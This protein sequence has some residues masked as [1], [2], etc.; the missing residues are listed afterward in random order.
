MVVLEAD[1]LTDK[2]PGAIVTSGT[3]DG[4]HIGHQKILKDIS[5]QAQTA[6]GHSVVLTFWPHPRFIINPADTTLK[7]LSTFEEKASLVEQANIDFLIKLRFTPA[8]SRMTPDEYVQQILID[9]LG[10]RKLVIG[11]DHRFG[12]G[13]EGNFSYLQANTDRFGFEVEEISR[14]DIDN[15]GVSSTKIRQ[16]LMDGHVY[17]AS[18]YLG[19]PYELS[20]TVVSGDKLGSTIGYPT[21]NLEINEPYKLV[22][23]EG[24]YAVKI[25]IG[26]KTFDGMMNIGTRPTV[27]GSVLKKEVH[28][29]DFSQEIYGQK[30]TIHFIKR[31]RDEKKFSGIDALKLQL[32]QDKRAAQRVLLK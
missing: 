19:R 17:V 9:K 31:I 2:I 1:Q 21:A 28:I 23:G 8:F 26:E 32:D 3:F 24:V 29:F 12:K 5:N 16:A 22:P 14:Q 7:L 15:I 11:Y 18:E 25:I 30:I 4:V 13:R 20:G 27:D 6:G 10:T